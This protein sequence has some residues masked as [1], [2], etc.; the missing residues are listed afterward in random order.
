MGLMMMMMM[1]MMNDDFL[2]VFKAQR[3]GRLI[4]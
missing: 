2:A 1:M 3:P 4:E